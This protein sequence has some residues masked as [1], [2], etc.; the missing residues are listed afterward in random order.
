MINISSALYS[1]P[2][3]A[4]TRVDV[5]ILPSFFFFFFFFF[6]FLVHFGP[7]RTFWLQFMPDSSCHNELMYCTR[8][9]TVCRLEHESFNAHRD[10]TGSREGMQLFSLSPRR[11]ARARSGRARG[12]ASSSSDHHITQYSQVARRSTTI[13]LSSVSF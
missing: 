9:D 11:Q 3:S 5:V 4:V 10:L 1:F 8:L 13:D 7:A 12:R 6:F 2:S